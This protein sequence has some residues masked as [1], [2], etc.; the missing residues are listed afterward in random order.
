MLLLPA[1]QPPYEIR[2]DTGDDTRR[3]RFHRKRVD[4]NDS[5]RSESTTTIPPE[6]TCIVRYEPFCK[7]VLL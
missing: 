4:G 3:Q 2:G 7:P 5:T 6:A 1:S